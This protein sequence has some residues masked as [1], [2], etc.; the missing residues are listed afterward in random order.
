M[1]SVPPDMFFKIM[2]RIHIFLYRISRGKIWKNMLGMPV[3]LL[4]TSGRKSGQPRTTPVVYLRD[5]DDYLIAAS[6]GGSASHPAWYF[7]LEATPE[8]RVEVGDQTFTARVT[9]TKDEER[10]LLYEKFKTAGAHFATYEQNTTRTIPV[11]R[12]TPV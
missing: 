9:I 8:V 6:K 11:V 7:N 5:D 4:T 2:N 1:A 12:L 10:D 3:L